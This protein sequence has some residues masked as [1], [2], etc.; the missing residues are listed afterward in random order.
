[1]LALRK[2]LNLKQNPSNIAMSDDLPVKYE[3]TKETYDEF[4]DEALQLKYGK[5]LMSCSARTPPSAN[6]K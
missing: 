5:K 4:L 6:V 1:M 2:C 3:I